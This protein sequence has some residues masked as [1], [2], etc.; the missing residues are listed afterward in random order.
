MRP[1]GIAGPIRTSP[2]IPWRGPPVRPGGGRCV[3]LA[4]LPV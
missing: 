4:V 2:P 3:A 1:S